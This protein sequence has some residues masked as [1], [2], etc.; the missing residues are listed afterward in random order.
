MALLTCEINCYGECLMSAGS[1]FV[2]S[3][4]SGAGKTSLLAEVMQHAEQLD[5]S[6]SYTTRPKRPLETEGENY[7]FIS[8]EKFDIMR[9]EHAFLESATVFGYEYGTSRAWVEERL[10]QNRDVVLEIDWQGAL[11]VKEHFPEAV[12]IFIL[13]PTIEHLEQRLKARAQDT[14]VVQ[15]ERLSQARL[16]ISKYEYFDYLIVNDDFQRACRDIAGVFQ[17]YTLTR[18]RQVPRLHDLIN[19]LL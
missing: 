8:P 1:L 16:E 13:P 10:Q 2:V 17:S 14:A 12:L 15:A 4:P 9:S 7:F 11:Q 18:S 19:S 3:A 5:V 6:V